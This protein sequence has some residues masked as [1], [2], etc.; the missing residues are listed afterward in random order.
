MLQDLGHQEEAY[1]LHEQSM[2]RKIRGARDLIVDMGEGE[3]NALA[4]KMLCLKT[5]IVDGLH[6]MAAYAREAHGQ[7]ICWD[8][9][10]SEPVAE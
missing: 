1:R 10:L 3:I 9:Y 7:P 6:L 8:G 2:L 4:R 5:L